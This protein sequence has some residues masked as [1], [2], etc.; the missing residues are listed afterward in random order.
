MPASQS[1]RW[2]V[3]L[4]GFLAATVAACGSSSG[5]T[6]VAPDAAAP[7]SDLGASADVAPPDVLG[8]PDGWMSPAF[9]VPPRADAGAASDARADAADAPPLA[10]PAPGGG[11]AGGPA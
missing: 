6:G 8:L 1:S 4:C 11:P 5:A 7:R 10:T 9:D 2:S 3:V